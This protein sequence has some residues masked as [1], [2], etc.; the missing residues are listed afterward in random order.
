MG[1]FIKNT[2]P[3]AQYIEDVLLS[4]TEYSQRIASAL[5]SHVGVCIKQN[6]YNENEFERF[7]SKDSFYARDYLEKVNKEDFRQALI[8]TKFDKIDFDVFY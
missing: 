1:Y 6:G 3:I 8:E 4:K 5:L 2:A 7:F